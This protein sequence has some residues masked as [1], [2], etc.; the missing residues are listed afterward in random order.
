MIGASDEVGYI[1]EPFNINRGPGICRAR[2]PLWFTYVRPGTGGE[3]VD[4]FGDM[5]AFRYNYRAQALQTRSMQDLKGLIRDGG[6][7]ARYRMQGLRPLI[8]DPIAVFSSEWIAESFDAQIVVIVR[9]PAAVASSIKR[10]GWTHP[11]S[12]FT[13]QPALIEDHLSAFRSEL[14]A[15]A[16]EDR[17]ILDQAAL[18]WRLIHST[19][20][21]YRGRHPDWVFVRHE[22][23][24][25]DPIGGFRVIFEALDLRY[26][27]SVQQVIRYSTSATNPADRTPG[28]PGF[29]VRD[30][31]ANI[32]NW[33]RR[34]TPAE[35][36]RIRSQVQDVSSR[37]Y[38]DEQW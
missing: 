29:G 8:K 13:G 1:H 3:L 2:F 21:D 12:H 19:I 5:L 24:S 11:F 28:E 22:D 26:T 17:D 32:D 9:H 10:L 20:A 35:I 14:D 31:R 18:L 25:R 15:F 6:Q 37:F 27:E 4:D 36:N 33:R 16:R 7:F 34:L 38:D 23:L 30:S